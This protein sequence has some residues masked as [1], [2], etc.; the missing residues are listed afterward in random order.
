MTFTVNALAYPADAPP[1]Y[2]VGFIGWRIHVRVDGPIA[3]N[4]F[5][6]IPFREPER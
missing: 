5:F 2:G 1:G 6:N 3:D 4:G